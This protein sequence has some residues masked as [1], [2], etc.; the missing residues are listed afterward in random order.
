MTIKVLTWNVGYGNGEPISIRRAAGITEVIAAAAPD[1]VCLQEVAGPQD[2]YAAE[3]HSLAAA[4]GMQQRWAVASRKKSLP[5][6]VMWN[7]HRAE[8]L[9]WDDSYADLFYHGAGIASFEVAGLGRPLSV[10]SVHLHPHSGN[11]RIDE[12]SQFHMKA[13]RGQLYIVAGDFNGLGP[14]HID[15]EPNWSE[16]RAGNVVARTLPHRP[17]ETPVGDRRVAW[18]MANVGF[19]DACAGSGDLTPTGSHIRIDWILV[20][21]ALAPALA[22]YSVGDNTTVARMSE[23]G[24]VADGK[25][26]AVS[27]H[28]PVWCL[29]DPAKV[30]GTAE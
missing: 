2:A 17:G 28:R 4:L 25:R 29:L 23:A 27:D 5:V 11:K 26:I 3:L 30:A 6:A 20:S 18:N 9:S 16:T 12:A 13:D 15:L 19:T 22:G 24:Q 10:A 1:L 8:L 7:P 14:E 21:R